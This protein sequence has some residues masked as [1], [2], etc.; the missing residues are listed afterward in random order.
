MGFNSGFKGLKKKFSIY[1]YFRQRRNIWCEGVWDMLC[2]AVPMCMPRPRKGSRVVWPLYVSLELWSMPP[3][4]WGECQYW[5]THASCERQAVDK[6]QGTVALTFWNFIL[7]VHDSNSGLDAGFPENSR[8]LPQFFQV[9]ATIVSKISPHPLPSLSLQL[10]Y[11]LNHPIMWGYWQ[12]KINS[13]ALVRERTI[14]TLTSPTGGGRSVGRSAT[15]KVVKQ[16][17]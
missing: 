15:D 5:Y 10:H 12:S 13:V 16:N 14:P 2:A 17:K 3:P 11:S 4:Q 6:E 9:T 8:A 1:F 7:E